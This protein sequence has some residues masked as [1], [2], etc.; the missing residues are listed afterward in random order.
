VSV[1]TVLDDVVAYGGHVCGI[2]IPCL[3]LFGCVTGW[4][5][6]RRAIERGCV[7]GGVLSHDLFSSLFTPI[8]AL[9][10]MVCGQMNRSPEALGDER[11]ISVSCR[12]D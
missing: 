7:V 12:P 3:L 4:V 10:R 6:N 5:V 8:S 2:L 9:A 11:S 1:S